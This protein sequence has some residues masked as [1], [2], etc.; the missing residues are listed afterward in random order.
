MIVSGKQWLA[1]A[2]LLVIVTPIALSGFWFSYPQW[3]ISDWDYYFSLHHTYRAII[4]KHHQFPFWNPVTCGGTA[5]LADP[6]FSVLT[7]TFLLEL[8]FGI[9]KGLRLAILL[10]TAVGGLGML[11]LGKQLKLPVLAALLPA[12]AYMF[13]SV[14]L[15]EIV[16][17]HVNVFSAMW[18]PW[19]F[20]S[21]LNSY[22]AKS[23]EAWAKADRY[24]L[25]CG[26][27]LALT[28][29]QAGIYL[30]MYTGLA[31]LLLPFLTSHWRQAWKVNIQA[32]LWALGLAALKLIP[33]FLWLRQFQDTAYASSTWTLSYLPKILLGRYLHG[34]DALPN[35][36]GGWH[37]YGAYIGPVV[38][39]LALLGAIRQR[40]RVIRGLLITA[41]AA[42]LLSSAGPLLKPLFDSAPFLPRSNISRFILFAIIP[43]SL[44]AGF[45]LARLLSIKRLGRPLA[46]L[47][48]ILA[49]VDLMTLANAL[50]QQ[51][52]IVPPVVPAISPAHPPLEFTAHTYDFT[53]PHREKYTRSYAAVLAGYGALNYCSSIGP[54]PMVR[55]IHDEGSHGIIQLSPPETAS[56]QPIQWSP[57][58]VQIIGTATGKTDLTLNT[59]YA[60][61]WRINHAPAKPTA[62]RPGLTL[63]EGP[64]D[65][66][67]S[68]HTPGFLLGLLITLATM[69]L[70]LLYPKVR[71]RWA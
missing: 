21:W 9:E 7:P 26:I 30:L 15:L 70:A 32:G 18:I 17:G 69:L 5:G 23:A 44:L 42:L 27:F 71:Q 20:W 16:E 22:R 45:G 58:R 47:V 61:G 67:F 4:L 10:A 3:G 13:S 6:E 40:Q 37:E 41:V 28:F 46:Y 59:N 39:A 56:L 14:N 25:M 8:I 62:G 43:L 66:T 29:Y 51:A 2:V 31:F 57:N 11:T 68:Y 48:I 63:T 64:F 33:V 19:I 38:L 12:A 50:S 36:G 65:L 49:A 34:S 1:A 60:R 53:A 54:E 24:T 55:T 35:Q 52:F